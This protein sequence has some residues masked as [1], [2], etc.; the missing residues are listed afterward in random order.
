MT[1]RELSQLYWLNREIEEDKRKLA[2]LETAAE[3]GSAKITGMPHVGGNGRS[4]ENYAV[5]IAEQRDLIE[6]KIRQTVI[7]YNRLN[8]YIAT[9]EDSLMRQ[10]LTLRYVDGMSW[11]QV[12]MSIGGGNTADSVRK[13]HDRFLQKK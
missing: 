11:L 5:L 12:A 7:L 3:G 9:V 4:I 6:M 2:E 1:K 10:I 8:R 13:A